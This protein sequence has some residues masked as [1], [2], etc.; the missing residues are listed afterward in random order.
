MLYLHYVYERMAD[1]GS[2]LLDESGRLDP[3]PFAAFLAE[4]VR[5]DRTENERR[6][7][8]VAAAYGR[9]GGSTPS[10]RAA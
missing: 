9:L 1:A 2:T 6:L 10:S 7:D 4:S 5:L 8:T 3:A